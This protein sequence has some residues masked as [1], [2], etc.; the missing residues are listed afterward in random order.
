MRQQQKIRTVSS[1]IRHKDN[2]MLIGKDMEVSHTSITGKPKSSPACR[3]S[4]I[5]GQPSASI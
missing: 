5:T 1:F 2:D 3:V 4:S